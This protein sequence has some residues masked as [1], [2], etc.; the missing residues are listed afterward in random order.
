MKR[1]DNDLIRVKNLINADRFRSSD[2]FFE[3]LKK[4][5]NSLLKDYFDFGEDVKVVISK[6]K[7]SFLVEISL[8]AD[9][10]KA[11]GSLPN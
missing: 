4:D 10:I 2:V 6:D 8:S 1:K 5:L 11:F 7:S 9:R 3:L